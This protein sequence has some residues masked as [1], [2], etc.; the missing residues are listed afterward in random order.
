MIVAYHGKADCPAAEVLAVNPFAPAVQ[1]LR[2]FG[3]VTAPLA[4][5]QKCRHAIQATSLY[6]SIT[7]DEELLS[8]VF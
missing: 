3:G 1:P 6:A 4:P 8:R 5:R 7:K 2:G